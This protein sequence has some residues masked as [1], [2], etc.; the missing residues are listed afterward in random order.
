M[1]TIRSL[2][3]LAFVLTACPAFA[4][5]PINQTHALAPDAELSVSN[6]A[7]SVTIQ[8]WDKH[9]VGI[10]GSLGSNSEL[11]L[12]GDAGDFSIKIKNKDSGMFGSDDMGPTTLKL[13]VPKGVH[14]DVDTVSASITAGGLAG[15]K[16]DLDTVSGN[17]RIDAD[18]PDVEIDSVS[19]DVQLAGAAAKLDVNSVSGDVR[20]D[21]VGAKASAQTVSGDV[22]LHG[23]PFRDVSVETVSGDI[24]LTGAMADKVKAKLHSMSGDIHLGMDGSPQAALDATSFSGDIHSAFGKV[25][26][27]TYGP[28][29]SL[30]F[31]LGNGDG[32]ITLNS[33]SGDIDIREGN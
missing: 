7:G 15:G 25:E 33:F 21:K 1:K 23:G 32:N 4:D 24:S 18:S 19:G 13:M 26:T 17:I 20:V 27:P 8:T 6:V 31:R 10:T 14:L 22:R 3:L 28:G 9:Q 30:H 29:S 5:T 12:S 16:L 11:K 2:L